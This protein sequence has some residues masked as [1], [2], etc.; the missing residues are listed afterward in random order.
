MS[1]KLSPPAFKVLVAAYN[2]QK[3]VPEHFFPRFF[4]ELLWE[5]PNVHSNR[6]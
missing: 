2:A 5:N 1:T 6:I 4:D 3:Q